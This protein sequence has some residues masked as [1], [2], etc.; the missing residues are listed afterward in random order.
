MVMFQRHGYYIV[1]WIWI[2][3][4]L[5]MATEFGRLVIGMNVLQRIITCTKKLHTDRAWLYVAPKPG[6][7][8]ENFMVE[9]SESSVTETARKIWE[10]E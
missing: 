2:A 5:G 10:S 4:E 7:L 3:L 1:G 6:Q 9:V 8:A